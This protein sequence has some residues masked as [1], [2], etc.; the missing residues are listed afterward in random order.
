VDPVTLFKEKKMGLLGWR[1]VFSRRKIMPLQPTLLQD[2]LDLI[3]FAFSRFNLHSFADLGG[4]WRV[5]GGYT[6]YTLDKYDVSVA[7]LVDNCFTDTVRKRARKFAQLKVVPGNFGN[8]R[9]ADEVGNVDAVF[10]FDVL[11]HQ[12]APDWHRI[13]EMYAPQTNCL[14]IYNPQW[15]RSKRTLRLLELGEEEYFRNVPHERTEE[16]YKDLFQKLGE[17]NPGH[18]RPWRDVSSIWQWGITDADLRAK[19]ESLGFKLQF[20][21]NCGRFGS[22]ANFENH[23]FVFSK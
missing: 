22:L 7:T 10:L 9:I 17:K 13:L 4:V 2:K 12:V 14:I 6:F 8:Q 15:I 20:M 3:D 11:L 16:P 1:T 19:V 21:K 18:D 23:A 5:E